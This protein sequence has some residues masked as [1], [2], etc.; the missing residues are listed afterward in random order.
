MAVLFVN[1]V[2]NRTDIQLYKWLAVA[3]V[4]L[5]PTWDVIIGYLVYFPACMFVPKAAIYETAETAGI[6]YEGGDYKN[7]VSSSTGDIRVGLGDL[8]LERGFKYMESLVAKKCINYCH[9]YES[10]PSVL[11]RCT[12]ITRNPE[13]P[14]YLPMKCI[15]IS[16]IQ[17]EYM[18]KVKKITMGITEINFMIINNRSTGKLMGEYN[19]VVRWPAYVPFFN[20]MKWRWWSGM[21]TSCPAKRQFYSFQYNVLKPK[22]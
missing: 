13:T 3:F 8:D 22:Q 19:E 7:Y 21:G 14:A 15:P 16:N 11:Y 20:W 5:L 6:Y 2:K 4:I 12:P 9:E 1:F 10:I 17:S 18:V